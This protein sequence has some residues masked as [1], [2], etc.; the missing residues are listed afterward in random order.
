MKPRLFI[1]GRMVTAVPHG[2][3]RYVSRLAEGLRRAERQS[4]LPYEVVFLAGAATDRTAFAGFECAPV[5]SPF[6]APAEIFEIPGLLARLG[7][8]FYHSP[9]FSSVLGLTCPWAVTIHDLNHLT[10]GGIG[11]KIYYR[12][13][14]A[15]FAR[16][17]RAL[18]TVSEFS[19]GEIARWLAVPADSVTVVPNALDAELALALPEAKI[20]EVLGRHGLARGKYFFCL[21]NPKL[22]KNV[23]LLL[24]AYRSYRAVAG[25][26]AWPLVLSFADFGAEPGV[27]GL[28]GVGD[29][30]GKALLQGAGAVAFPSLYE[31]F[32]LPPLEAVCAGAP[33]LVS[34]IAPHREGLVDLSADEACWL[35]PRDVAA[36]TAGLAAASRGEIRAASAATRGRVLARFSV[37]ALGQG[38]DHIYRS[39]LGIQT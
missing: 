14:L 23:P 32:G 29:A 4:P 3:S 21:S 20:F 16:R 37:E 26:A 15:R 13:L 33:L 24:A 28:P 25:E 22:H 35:D 31:G 7:A 18:L 39:V 6:L 11:Q 30:E 36:W 19:R 5:R 38:M 9:T 17:S 8:A 10:Y 2:F 12:T 34:E 27:R 1:D